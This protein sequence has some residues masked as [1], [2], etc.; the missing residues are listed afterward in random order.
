MNYFAGIT[1][2]DKDS[3]FAGLKMVLTFKPYL[4]LSA[5]FLFLS[6]AV[7]VSKKFCGVIMLPYNIRDL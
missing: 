3:F 2:A 6:L 5:S 4:I 7:A 1:T